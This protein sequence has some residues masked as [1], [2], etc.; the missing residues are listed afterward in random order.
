MQLVYASSG[1]GLHLWHGPSALDPTQWHPGSAD[2]HDELS[3]LSQ[4][5]GL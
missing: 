5:L 1:E 2:D 4:L 3:K